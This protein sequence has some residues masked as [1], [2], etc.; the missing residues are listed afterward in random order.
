MDMFKK[1]FLLTII[2]I[3]FSITASAQINCDSVKRE[4]N[5]QIAELKK[6]GTSAELIKSVE[7]SRDM[8]LKMYCPDAKT[9][10][11]K[12]ENAVASPKNI[13]G[14][15]GKGGKTSLNLSTTHEITMSITTKD[16]GVNTTASVTYYLAD[17]G[18]SIFIPRD[19][20]KGK[21][22]LPEET[23]GT[24]DGWYMPFKGA[25]VMYA[26][27]PEMGKIAYSMPSQ[28]KLMINQNTQNLKVQKT[29][30]KKTV[31]GYPC[32]GYKVTG[33][34][35]GET[36]SFNCFVSI[37]SLPFHQK[38]YAGLSMIPASTLGITGGERRGVLELTGKSGAD[39]M[40]MTVTSMKP[41]AKKITLSGYTIF[42]AAAY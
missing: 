7:S 30:A 1:L 3:G 39:D 35:N 26:T 36:F 38:G 6:Q 27:N 19:G 23:E 21:G 24:F 4:F 41:L 29:G 33:S 25:Q 13:N 42:G 34:Q 2:A 32:D 11:A 9:A 8:L 5:K 37:G 31:A 10:Q 15:M 28:Q 20:L 16:E 14:T 18:E 17:N 22:M 40:S 12:E